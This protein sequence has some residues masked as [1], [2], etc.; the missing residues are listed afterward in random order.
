[1][2]TIKKL[3]NARVFLNGR[4]YGGMAEE[5]TLPEIK[6]VTKEHAPCALSG[7]LDIPVGTDKMT[8][9]LKGDFDEA[10]VAAMADI[11]HIHM[12]QVRC[13]MPGYDAGGRYQ[14]QSVVAH[15]RGLSTGP[16][17]GAIKGQEPGTVEYTLNVWAYKL[18]VDG[19][20]LFD[21]DIQNRKHDVLGKN[22]NATGNSNLG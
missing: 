16:K 3:L 2:D 7:K 5:V 20:P 14:E 19:I 10:F 17:F 21:I 6:A 22:L 9:Q 18:E 12:I 1:M 11:H 15:I 8:L 13:N 4:D